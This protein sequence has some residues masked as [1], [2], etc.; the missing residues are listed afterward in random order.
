M[1]TLKEEKTFK[2]MTFRSI[3]TFKDKNL[4][5]DKKNKKY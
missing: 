3:E 1:K 4:V 2:I 5:W